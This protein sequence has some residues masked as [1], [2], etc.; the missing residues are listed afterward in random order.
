MAGHQRMN[1]FRLALRFRGY[2][3]RTLVKLFIC[4]CLRPEYFNG[5]M[6][7]RDEENFMHLS[8]R[9]MQS[10]LRKAEEAAAWSRDVM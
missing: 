2:V 8:D 4:G 9:S 7:T 6:Q 3:A 5:T 10:K 1:N